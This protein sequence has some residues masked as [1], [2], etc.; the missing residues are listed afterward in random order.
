MSFDDTYE[1]HHCDILLNHNISAKKSRYKNLVP[2]HCQLK[3][4]SDYTLIRD[5]FKKI[6]KKRKKAPSRKKQHLFVAIGGADH[7]NIN[8]KILKA[9]LSFKHFCIDVVTTTANKNLDLLK[10]YVKDHKN[11]HLHVNSTQIAK[12]MNR[13]DFAIITPSVTVHETL[14]LGTPFIAIKTASNQ[15]DMYKYLKKKKFLVLK[16]FN[17]QKFKRK[18]E[19]M[20]FHLK[21]Q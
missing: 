2:K 6:K 13:A 12:L 3:C 19:K 9:L 14:Y 4:G 16:K 17:D 8:I 18:V 7:S 15:D 5:E 11:I 10:R 1:K 20:I 21:A